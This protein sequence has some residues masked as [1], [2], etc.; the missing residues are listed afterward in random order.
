MNEGFFSDGEV[1]ATTQQTRLAKCGLCKLHKGTD[2]P[3][4]EPT[5]SGRKG[6]LIVGDVPEPYGS[7]NNR[8]LSDTLRALGMDIDDC[9]MTY[10][11]TCAP[12][13]KFDLTDTQIACCRP[14]LTAVIKEHQPSVIIPLGGQALNAVIGDRWPGDIGGVTRWRGWCIPDRH[15]NAWVCPTYHPSYLQRVHDDDVAHLVFED[16]LERALDKRLDEMPEYEDETKLVKITRNPKQVHAYLNKLMANPPPLLGHDW[17]ATGTKPHAPGHRVVSLALSTGPN[18]GVAFPMR[19]EYFPKLHTIFT[20]PAIGKIAHGAKFEHNW[21]RENIKCA[22][23]PWLWCTQQA[24]HVID[25]RKAKVNGLKFQLY[26]QFGILGYDD[27]TKQFLEGATIPES[28]LAPYRDR[29]SLLALVDTP[30]KNGNALNDIFRMSLRKLLTYN[31]IDALGT[32][33]LALWQM[34]K[35]GFEIPNGVLL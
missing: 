31:A 14:N 3:R 30:G 27:G 7:K 23:A 15:L 12:E 20:H 5:G 1:K 22:T 34:A 18:H 35:L 8:K 25:N 13:D 24:S 2:D 4:A 28:L 10:A 21:T 32:V 11:V 19:K 16:D 6:I 33:R 29:P 26:V 17:E 9:I